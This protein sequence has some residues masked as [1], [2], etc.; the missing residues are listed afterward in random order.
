MK[1][2]LSY[3]IQHNNGAAFRPSEYMTDYL[4]IE[5]SHLIH[6][7]AERRTEP[8]KTRQVP[9]DPW[10]M[11][12]AFTA[13]HNPFQALKSD[14]EEEEIQKIPSFIGRIYAS[15]IKALDR[16]VGRIIEALKE[17][18]QYDNTIIIFTSDNGA[19]PYVGLPHLNAPYRGW[20]ATLF[21]GGVRIPFFLQW[22]KK[23]TEVNRKVNEMIIHIDLFPTLL[24]LAT[25]GVQRLSEATQLTLNGNN[26]LSHLL[27]EDT[28]SD[29]SHHLP[30]SVSLDSLETLCQSNASSPQPILPANKDFSRIFFWR[31]GSYKALRYYQ[32]KL[33]VHSYLDKVWFYDLKSDPTE[34]NNLINVI[35]KDLTVPI[36]ESQLLRWIEGK[37]EVSKESELLSSLLFLYQQL[38]LVDAR[39]SKPSWPALVE[40]P[41]C[42]DKPQLEDDI[43][44]LKDEY[45]IWAN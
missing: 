32:Y 41:I 23:I 28:T 36:T 10:F 9:D 11:T 2:M 12:V 39:Q 25:R 13:P 30:N 4:G 22:P 1:R 35:V 40:L 42:I 17:T 20:K 31:S 16:N 34:Q 15:M 21:E 45:I 6:K 37:E 19:A 7:L 44:T 3:K 24:S 26:F 5:S 43:C 29:S 14:Y 33:Q 38:R 18:N 27:E 8:D